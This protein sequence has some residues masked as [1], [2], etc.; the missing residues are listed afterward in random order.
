M[1]KS[2]YILAAAFMRAKSHYQYIL[3]AGLIA[4]IVLLVYARDLEILANETLQNEAL[5]HVLLLPF[6]A[7]FLFYLKRD[8]VKGSMALEKLRKK[9]KVKYVDEMIGVILCLISFLIYWYGSYTFYPLEYHMFSLPILLAGITLIM[10]NLKVLTV[11]IFPILFLFF[12]VPLPADFMYAIGGTMANVNTQ[13]SYSIL[14]VLGLPVS[15][16]TTYGPPTILLTKSLGQPTSFTVDLPCSGIYSL[17]AFAMF[18][19]FLTM[20]VSTSIPRKAAVVLIGFITFEILNIVRI[21]TIISIAYW[22][23]E[24]IAMYLFHA[25]AGLILIFVGMIFT[26]FAAEKFLKIQI[27]PTSQKQQPCPECTKDSQNFCPNCGKLLAPLQKHISRESWAKLTLLLLACSI[28]TL[29]INA[30]TFVAA[31]GP[32]GVTSSVGWENA[33]D[34]FPQLP[35][36]RLAFLY[37]DTDYEKI[38]RQDASLMYAY[39]PDNYSMP[40]VYVSVGISSSISNLH[41]WE[42]CLVTWQ[43]AQGQYPLVSVLDSRDTQLLQ[44]VPLIARYMVFVSPYNYTQV[45]LY[46]YEKIA[47]NTGITVEQKYARISLIILTEVS[48]PYSQFENEL[49]GIGQNI[50]SYWEPLKTQSLISLGIPLQQSLL[51]FS[52]GFVAFT[53]MAQYSNDWRKKANNVQL[54]N[55]FASAREKTVLQTALDVSKNK[56]AIETRD[57][58]DALRDRIGRKVKLE[59]LLRILNHLE[60]YGLI[61]KD[62]MTVNNQPRLVW[63]TKY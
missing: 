27:L 4:A 33:T 52:V 37:R 39:L 18:A 55:R 22:F 17:I 30:P 13:A 54:F 60:E 32:I 21:S 19:F 8:M 40:T 44:D 49:S 34:V 5:N 6:F 29:S 46:W 50:A 42:V 36:Y 59:T 15:L 41:S 26:L 61:G 3:S 7:G 53:K 1:E 48:S 47:F 35:E 31:Q 16:S 51:I 45:T 57:I 10:F 56:K 12:I 11:L 25:V 38:S 28:V 2:R 23:G 20:V 24:E 9:T 43:T 14:K 58:R 63:K 62:I